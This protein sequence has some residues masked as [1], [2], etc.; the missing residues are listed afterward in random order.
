MK[1]RLLLVSALVAAI[2]LPITIA[3]LYG[4]GTLLQAMGDVSGAAGV[5]R[6][7]LACGIL[8]G[9]DLISL[10]V[11]LATAAVTSGIPVPREDL[12][13]PLED[14]PSDEE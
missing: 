1:P 12:R 7:A 2:L 8:W 6:V 9:L 14:S 13:P 4:V 10:I 11:M 5:G 3:V